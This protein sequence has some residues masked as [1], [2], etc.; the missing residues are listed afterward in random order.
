MQIVEAIDN[1]IKLS[2]EKYIVSRTN[3]DGIIEYVNDYFYEISRYSK[4]EL[5]GKHHT[6]LRHPDTP[7]IIFKMIEERIVKG[8]DI[9]AIVKK[10]AKCGSYFWVVTD[11]ESRIDPVTNK[12]FSHT[13]L[14]RYV[15]QKAIDTINLIYR[16]L[17]KL[18][19]EY[20]IQASEKYLLNFLERNN[21]TY[22]E[23]IEKLLS[24]EGQ[25]QLNPLINQ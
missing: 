17:L 3:S 14:K 10:R 20:N 11:F 21:A 18:E 22:D 8:E 7:T 6:I 2:N 4:A 19:K 15:P 24:P 13:A 16:K 5:I 23:Y 9:R 25:L 12:F 1:E